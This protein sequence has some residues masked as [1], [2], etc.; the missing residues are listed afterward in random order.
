MTADEIAARLAQVPGWALVQG[1][2]QKHYGFSDYHR[3]MAFV[4]ALAWIA[5]AEDHH[6]DLQVSYGGCTVRFSTHSVGGL[7]INDF[8]CAAKVDA[9]LP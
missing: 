9:L 8:I 4:N 5:H 7:S 6:P 1:A 3:T 2:I